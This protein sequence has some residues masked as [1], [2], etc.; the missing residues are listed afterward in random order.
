MSKPSKEF[1]W[2]MQGMVYALSIA[3]KD[4]VEAL[5]EEIKK[6]GFFRVSIGL[7]QKDY[8]EILDYLVQNLHNTY[9]TVTGVV[10]HDVFGFGKKRLTDFEIAFD[11]KT[12]D[13]TDFDYLGQH[14]VTLED[15]ATQLREE[16]GMHIDVDRVR[17]CQECYKGEEAKLMADIREL[18]KVLRDGGFESA[19]Q[20]IEGKM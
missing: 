6:R 18:I 4:G 10:L 7:P 15:Y 8:D 1:E 11:R 5:E 16:F 14:Y 19:A 20:F 9:K 17:Q 13:A 3:K 12:R 2:R